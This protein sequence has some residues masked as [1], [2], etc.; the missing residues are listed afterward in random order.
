MANCKNFTE[1]DVKKSLFDIDETKAPGPDG[2]T[3][4]F[5]RKL[6]MYRG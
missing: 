5:S 6:A 2:Y 1:D 4:G 3:N